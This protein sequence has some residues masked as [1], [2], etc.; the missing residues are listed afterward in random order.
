MLT[1]PSLTDHWL[2]LVSRVFHE[3]TPLKI[4]KVV[5]V[6]ELVSVFAFGT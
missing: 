4:D 1:S 2:L 6:N 5:Y 3:H